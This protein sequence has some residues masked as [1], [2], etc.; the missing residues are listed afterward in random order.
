M[1]A[2]LR[3]VAGGLALA[4]HAV[5]AD[6]AGEEFDRLLPAQQRQLGAVDGFESGQ[7]AAGW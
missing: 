6:D 3:E 4:V 1:P 5:G 7:R 2:Q